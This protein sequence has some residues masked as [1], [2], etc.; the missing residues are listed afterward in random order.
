M[1]SA[2]RLAQEK[3][4]EGFLFGEPGDPCE[5][6]LHFLIRILFGCVVLPNDHQANSQCFWKMFQLPKNPRTTLPSAFG[7]TTWQTTPG[8]ISTDVAMSL[9]EAQEEEAQTASLLELFVCGKNN[10]TIVG[11]G[12]KIES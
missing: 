10:E 3:S 8:A 12:K 5:V 2:A 7:K 11:G 1:S 4:W 6:F 9:K